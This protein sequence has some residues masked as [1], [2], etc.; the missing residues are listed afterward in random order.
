MTD[1]LLAEVERVA[2]LCADD[3]DG[4]WLVQKTDWDSGFATIAHV[5]EYRIGIETGVKGGNYRDYDLG[6]CAALAHE[7]AALRNLFHEHGAALKEA[8]RLYDEAN[9]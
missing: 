1:N 5:S 2:K 7:I 4:I 6:D 3:T 8:A 9:P